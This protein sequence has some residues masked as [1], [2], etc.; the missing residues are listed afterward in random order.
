[1]ELTVV[2]SWYM[3]LLR[4]S[5]GIYCGVVTSYRKKKNLYLRRLLFSQKEENLRRTLWNKNSWH[6][7]VW[8]QCSQYKVMHT[9]II[10]Y[11]LVLC[12]GNKWTLCDS[13]KTLWKPCGCRWKEICSTA[14]TALFRHLNSLL[15]HNRGRGC[16]VVWPKTKEKCSIISLNSCKTTRMV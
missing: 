16:L 9:S 11:V 12:S 2:V 10:L 13:A 14:N 4:I 3:L 1:M 6:S 15:P 7:T 8:N 5:W